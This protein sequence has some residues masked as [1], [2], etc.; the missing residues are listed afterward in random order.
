MFACPTGVCKALLAQPQ[1]CFSVFVWLRSNSEDSWHPH[2]IS[3]DEK[4]AGRLL[5]CLPA[6]NGA[7][8]S[9]S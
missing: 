9:G 2:E 8:E 5:A 3:D 4:W 1:R 6:W 7:I